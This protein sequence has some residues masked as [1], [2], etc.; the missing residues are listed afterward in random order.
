MSYLFPKRTR[1][2]GLMG[3]TPWKRFLLVAS[4]V[5]FNSGHSTDVEANPSSEN[6][7]PQTHSSQ[8]PACGGQD[9][10]VAM[11]AKVRPSVLAIGTYYFKDKPSAQYVGTGFVIDDGRTIVTNAHVIET[12][13]KNDR[14][15]YLTIFAPDTR[16]KQGRR[17][18]FMAEDKFHDVALLRINDPALPPLELDIDGALLQ[19]QAVGVIGYPL[20]MRLGVVPAVHK[21]VV[22]AV[23]SAV[24]PLPEGAKLTPELIRA[25]RHPYMLYQLDVVVFPGNSGSPLFDAKTGRVI[26]LINR[27]LAAKTREHLV[28]NPSGIAYAV[29]TRWIHELLVRSRAAIRS[30]SVDKPLTPDP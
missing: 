18:V 13:R 26:G 20:G 27:T 24:R 12:I 19:G 14:L 22:A 11:V 6:G 21:G 3:K 29:E 10:F 4:I 28:A 15:E 23:V 17:A 25:L 1:Q 8:T 9:P 16:P 5:I 7:R 30:R 2:N